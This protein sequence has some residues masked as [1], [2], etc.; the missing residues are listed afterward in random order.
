MPILQVLRL[1]YDL[2][3]A[4][5]QYVLDEVRDLLKKNSR[6]EGASS[7]VRLLRFSDYSVDMEVYAYILTRDYS[8]YLALQEELILSIL[9]SIEKTGVAIALPSQ[10]PFLVDTWIDPEKAKAAKARMEK[11]LNPGNSGGG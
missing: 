9:D 1:R 11:T 6:V 4:H 10:G 8:E 3:A 7:R 5:F 2:S